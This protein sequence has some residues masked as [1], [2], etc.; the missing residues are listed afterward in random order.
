[1]ETIG[2]KIK[3]IRKQYKLSPIDFANRIGISQGRL[4]EIEQGKTKHSA[5]TLKGLKDKFKL[6]LN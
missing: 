3:A 1:M 4:S 2:D 5:D 6:D